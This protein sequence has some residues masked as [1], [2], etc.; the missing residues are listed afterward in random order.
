MALPSSEGVGWAKAFCKEPL[1]INFARG[2]AMPGLLSSSFLT[3]STY[4]LAEAVRRANAVSSTLEA[5][6]TLEPRGAMAPKR[7]EG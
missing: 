1:R 2:G 7:V 4:S 6:G 3:N 5:L